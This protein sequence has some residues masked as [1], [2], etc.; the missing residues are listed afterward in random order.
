MFVIPVAV[1]VSNS[2]DEF[3]GAIISG[4]NVKELLNNAE[5]VITSGNAFLLVNRDT[6]YTD[7][8]KI[9]LA[10]ANSPNASEDYE[11][12]PALVE[13][14]KDWI[15]PSGSLP[16]SINAGRYKYSYYTLVDGYQL[17]ILVGFN[18]VEFWENVLALSA[19]LFVGMLLL[20]F[21]ITKLVGLDKR[22]VDE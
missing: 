8:E 10:S 9:L 19:Q 16:I 1:G 6:F 7:P 5:R 15:D 21:L 4:I 22:K 12:L 2:R 3:Q 13:Q 17:A 20:C 14:L 18:R 11:K